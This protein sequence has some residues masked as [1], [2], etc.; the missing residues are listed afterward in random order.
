MLMLEVVWWF[1]KRELMPASTP[2]QIHRL[3]ENRF[4]VSDLDGLIEL[5]SP[6]RC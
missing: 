1:L 2:E 6:M 5:M 4:N 3:F